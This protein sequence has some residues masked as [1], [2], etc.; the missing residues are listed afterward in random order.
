MR[1]CAGFAGWPG[2]IDWKDRASGAPKDCTNMAR[3]QWLPSLIPMGIYASYGRRSTYGA[4]PRSPSGRHLR[5]VSAAAQ[6]I[7]NGTAHAASARQVESVLARK[8]RPTFF[9]LPAAKKV[10]RHKSSQ[11]NDLCLW[12]PA[13]G[14][15][16][17]R[18]LPS[19][20]R[21]FPPFFPCPF[22]AP[23]SLGPGLRT[24]SGPKGRRSGHREMFALI[25]SFLIREIGA[26]RRFV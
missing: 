5:S 16:K 23:A 14:T 3:A 11:I 9:L 10:G 8:W 21:Q 15:E 13:R 26:I 1:R 18:S 20:K 4:T 24:A 6:K 2:H 22:R 12:N 25:D 7:R 19:K 17:W